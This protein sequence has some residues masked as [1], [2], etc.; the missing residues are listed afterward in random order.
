MCEVTEGEV[1]EGWYDSIDRISW[2]CAKAHRAQTPLLTLSQRHDA[3]LDGIIEWVHQ[4]GIPTSDAPLFRAARAAIEAEAHH[5]LKHLNHGHFWVEPPG[6]T[7]PIGETVTDKVAAWQIAWALTEHQWNVVYALTEA[8][9]RGLTW[10]EAAA[11]LDMKP[12]AYRQILM[13]AR[14]KARE[15][16]V[17]PG[18]TPRGHWARGGTWNLDHDGQPNGRMAGRLRR[19]TRDR[20]R[21]AA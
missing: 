13:V 17:A 14:K 1:S 2:Y 12:G 10:H 18:D 16:W 11:A 9:R 21:K 20:Q 19:R 15:L 7:D 4:H 6:I 8:Y 5:S 3:A